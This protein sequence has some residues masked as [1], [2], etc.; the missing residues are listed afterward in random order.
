MESSARAFGPARRRRLV[1]P[2]DPNGGAYGAA[3]LDQPREVVGADRPGRSEDG[4]ELLRDSER[5]EPPLAVVVH[6]LLLARA[7]VIV[8][9][10]RLGLADAPDPTADRE[11]RCRK[12]RGDEEADRHAQRER[13]RDPGVAGCNRRQEEDESADRSREQ[14]RPDRRGSVYGCF[15]E[16]SFR[17]ATPPA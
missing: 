9:R 4:G 6:T 7:L 10:R 17:Q 11:D 16:S 15:R 1:R 8:V 12:R 2:D 14:P 13:G 3:L 5:D